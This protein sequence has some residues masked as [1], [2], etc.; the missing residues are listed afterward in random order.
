[1]YEEM[2]KDDLIRELERSKDKLGTCTLHN[3]TLCHC[4]YDVIQ[5]GVIVHD[6]DASILFSN[7]KAM[8][9]LCLDMP[10]RGKG[11]AD[12]E[13]V[14]YDESDIRIEP[15]DNPVNL[16][17]SGQKPV[18]NMVIKY[19]RQPSD[20]HCWL[21]VTAIPLISGGHLEQVVVSFVD[22]TAEIT[23]TLGLKESEE[24]LRETLKAHRESEE[25]FRAIFENAVMGII[26]V[27]RGGQIV[28]ANLTIENMLGYPVDELKALH[29]WDISFPDDYEIDRELLLDI[30]EGRRQYYQIE[31]RYVSQGGA[32]I[33]GM[34]TASTVRDETGAPR[35]IVNMIE[36][37]SASKFA[38]EQLRYLNTHDTMTGL[39]NRAWFDEELDRLQLGM[40][41]PVS[42]ITIDLDGLK[43]ANDTQGHKA[44]DSLIIGAATILREAFHDQDI[45]AR[46]GGDEFG[47]LLPAT[48]EAAVSAILERIREC[49]A[50]FNETR[51]ELEVHFSTGTAT[52]H[53]S[54]QIAGICKEADER[55]YTEKALHK[56]S[57]EK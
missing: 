26:I 23:A 55:M 37:I 35:F 4:I 10:I 38:E 18:E 22:I 46:T 45:A 54:R 14:L 24:R 8:E 43:K 34:L 12:P 27:H 5:A 30:I 13:W 32:L 47:I 16:A 1:M 3:P 36:D 21:R 28:N 15:G 42:V 6:S 9:I 49:Q 17:I 52:A 20:D 57:R 33:W 11:F 19:H 2:T 39:R 7:T 41:L 31:K 48:D 40:H 25:C 51:H 50:R 44:G 29:L 53:S 56:R